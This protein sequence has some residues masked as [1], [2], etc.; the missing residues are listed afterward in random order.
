MMLLGK[1]VLIFLCLMTHHIFQCLL[2]RRVTDKLDQHTWNLMQSQHQLTVLLQ[3][4]KK[5]PNSE[6]S[7]E[8]MHHNLKC[9]TT[10]VQKSE[11]SFS[12]VYGKQHISKAVTR[13]KKRIYLRRRQ[14]LF[15]LCCCIVSL[16]YI[17]CF[18]CG[19]VRTTAT[20]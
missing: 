15:V 11:M 1:Q 14:V 12:V 20:E 7:P 17:I 5:S 6:I 18:V 4:S 13:G 10:S 19:S 9:I 16:T 2:R 3:V 8:D